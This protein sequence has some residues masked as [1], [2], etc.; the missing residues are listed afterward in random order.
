MVAMVRRSAP[1]CQR[2]VLETAPGTQTRIGRRRRG[3]ARHAF[4][5]SFLLVEAYW[6]PGAAQ[7]CKAAAGSC[8]WLYSIS[9]NPSK[10]SPACTYADMH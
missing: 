8:Q 4:P 5:C 1:L 9:G 10:P 2:L 6:C 3:C 7:H